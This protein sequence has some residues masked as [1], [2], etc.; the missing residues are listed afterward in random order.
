MPLKAFTEDVNSKNGMGTPMTPQRKRELMD[1]IHRAAY[2]KGL[3]LKR[4]GG[5]PP[6][7]MVEKLN[8][9]AS[10]SAMLS[11]DE[12][13]LAR[14]HMARQSQ[15]GCDTEFSRFAQAVGQQERSGRVDGDRSRLLAAI[16]PQERGRIAFVPFDG[17]RRRGQ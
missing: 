4:D 5:Q 17:G 11:G 1:P 8:A 2:V 13:R 14:M 6:H 12:A 16:G 3:A 15:L 7:D 10:H 9:L